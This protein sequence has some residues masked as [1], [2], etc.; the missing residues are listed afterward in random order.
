[1]TVAKSSPSLRDNA[2]SYNGKSKSQVR[3]Q[4]SPPRSLSTSNITAYL[5]KIG[6]K[7]RDFAP[8]NTPQ[9]LGRIV[10]DRDSEVGVSDAF[11][12]GLVWCV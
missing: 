11:G 6:A 12:L 9:R 8:Q 2:L 3:I 1:M 5:A 7:Q 10:G 4:L